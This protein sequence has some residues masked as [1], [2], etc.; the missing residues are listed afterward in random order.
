MNRIEECNASLGQQQVETIQQTI[1]LMNSYKNRDRLE[2]L[3]RT[4]IQKCIDWCT[5]HKVEYNRDLT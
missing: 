4:N 3:L 2:Q 1:A 5:R